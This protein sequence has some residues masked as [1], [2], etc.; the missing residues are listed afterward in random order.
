MFNNESKSPHQH[1]KMEKLIISIDA[2]KAFDE[3]Y[4][5]SIPDLNN[6]GQTRIIENILNLIKVIYR[7]PTVNAMPNVKN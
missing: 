4:I 2:E 1:T 6:S 3:M 5:T 7:I